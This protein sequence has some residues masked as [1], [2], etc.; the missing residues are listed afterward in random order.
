MFVLAPENA[1]ALMRQGLRQWF[2]CFFCAH[3]EQ[4]IPDLFH[5]S[6]PDGAL[7]LK[8]VGTQ[9]QPVGTPRVRPLA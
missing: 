9:I 5:L 4:K 7:S 6:F 8:V 2:L 1:E 3:S